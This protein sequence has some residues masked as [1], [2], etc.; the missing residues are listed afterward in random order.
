M[1]PILPL[2]AFIAINNIVF[3]SF[4][5]FVISWIATIMGCLLS[6]YAFRLGF[7]KFL[8]RNIK[9]DGK[10]HKFMNYVT[11]ISLAKLTL[12][13]AL[14]FT[15]AFFVNIS[16][17]LSKMDFKRYFVSLLIGK[18]SIVYFWGYIGTSLIE[19]IKDP[20]VL[21]EVLALMLIAYIISRLI[22]RYLNM[23]GVK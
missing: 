17:G 2:G 3:G 12:L 23:N 16:A 5:G 19:S 11:K 6:F 8:Y 15:P 18:L 20:S 21:L 10:V 22:Q 4:W 9:I 7:S 14:P 1:R 13:V